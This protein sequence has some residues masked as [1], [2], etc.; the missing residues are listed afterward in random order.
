LSYSEEKYDYLL[1]RL[2][3]IDRPWAN[4]APRLIAALADGRTR[5]HRQ[6]SHD[7]GCSTHILRGANTQLG[8]LLDD[9]FVGRD[10][11]FE[12]WVDG[13]R[14]YQYKMHADLVEILRRRG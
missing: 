14:S 8:K 10:R 12:W 3:Q 1:A 9:E 5:E 4:L 13:A 2:E 6:L 11:P 7:L